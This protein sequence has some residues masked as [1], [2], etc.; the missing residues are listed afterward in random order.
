MKNGKECI[1]MS[2]AVLR[3]SDGKY[4][5]ER[6]WQPGKFDKDLYEAAD[7]QESGQQ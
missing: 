7:S 1:R 3:R 2:D 4:T 6:K 5:I